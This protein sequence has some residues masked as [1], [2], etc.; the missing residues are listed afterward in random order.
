MSEIRILFMAFSWVKKLVVYVNGL[1][2]HDHG[3]CPYKV[4]IR[5]SGLDWAGLKKQKSLYK[6]STPNI[7]PPYKFLWAYGSS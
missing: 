6:V 5:W 4:F 2:Q 7:K 3:K 1:L